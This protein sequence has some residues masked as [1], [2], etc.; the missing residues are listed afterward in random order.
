MKQQQRSLVVMTIVVA[1]LVS[2]SGPLADWVFPYYNVAQ[3]TGP[4]YT[5][6]LIVA[7]SGGDYTSIASAVNSISSPGNNSR[8]L[9]WVAPAR[10]MSR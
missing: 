7:A 6:V 3:A 8:Y 2:L 4:Q 1:L 10:I 5:G 9:V